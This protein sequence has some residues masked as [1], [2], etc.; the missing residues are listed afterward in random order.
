MK[1]GTVCL[2]W[3]GTAQGK[4]GAGS[5]GASGI[6]GTAVGGTNLN[7]EFN[8]GTVSKVQLNYGAV[9]L[10]FVP[11]SFSDELML[12][13]R[14]YE[15]SYDVGTAPGSVNALG[16]HITTTVA[17]TIGAGLRWILGY[18]PRFKVRKRIAPTI[19]LYTVEGAAGSWFIAT[20][21]RAS[22]ADI[23]SENGFVVVNNTGGSLTTSVGEAHGHWIADA[24]L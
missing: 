21:N 17:T 4:I 16:F 8:A 20:S 3:T 12:C 15:K 19:T 13:Q 6:T 14:Y 2:S 10:P 18:Y 1:Y 24:E 23:I 7:I 22:S 5:F 11:R 9:A